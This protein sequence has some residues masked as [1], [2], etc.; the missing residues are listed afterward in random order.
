MLDVNEAGGANH[1]VDLVIRAIKEMAVAGKVLLGH[2]R[3]VLLELVTE[4]KHATGR[5]TSTDRLELPC[6]LVPEIQHVVGENDIDRRNRPQLLDTAND[7]FEAALVH[8]CPIS[9]TRLRDHLGGQV[10][11]PDV[12]M[13]KRLQRVLQPNSRAG[14]ELDDTTA[15]RT[16][17]AQLVH[18]PPAEVGVAAGHGAPDETPNRAARPTEL[19]GDYLQQIARHLAPDGALMLPATTQN[20]CMRQT[21]E[22]AELEQYL[23]HIRESPS[24]LGTVELISRRPAV[25]EREVVTEARLD[26]HEGLVGDTWRA[27]GSSRRPD[28]SP[29]PEAQLTLMNARIAAAVAGERDRWALAG[30]QLFVDLDISQANMPPGAR[31]QVGE[32]VIEFSASPHTGCAKYSARFGVEALKFINSPMGRELRLRGAN[33]RVIVSGTVRQSDTIRTL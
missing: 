32:A 17:D 21:A 20:T 11:A 23:D 7:Q 15:C 16:L 26:L 12:R 29:D 28:G 10:D 30:D 24:D 8:R 31:V 9:S 5:K 1:C 14:S 33:C 25:D 2:R 4:R 27:R 22:L 19:P 13:R 18:N 6:R 3:H